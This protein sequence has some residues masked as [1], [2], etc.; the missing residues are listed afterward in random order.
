MPKIMLQ[1]EPQSVNFAD[2]K[3]DCANAK[4]KK[5]TKAAVSSQFPRPSNASRV[6]QIS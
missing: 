6:T 3:A 2:A 1:N 4:K 5:A